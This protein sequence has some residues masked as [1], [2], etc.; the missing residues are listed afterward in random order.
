MK[1]TFAVTVVCWMD[2]L[3]KSVSQII[4]PWSSLRSIKKYR[5]PSNKKPFKLYIL[6]HSEI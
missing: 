5:I 6:P 4:F 2:F 3:T 1:T